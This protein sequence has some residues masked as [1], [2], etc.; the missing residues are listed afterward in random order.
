MR[1]CV[2]KGEYIHIYVSVYVFTMFRKNKNKK[3]GT[4]VVQLHLQTAASSRTRFLYTT[5]VD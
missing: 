3:K 4:Y 5:R 2:Y 1:T